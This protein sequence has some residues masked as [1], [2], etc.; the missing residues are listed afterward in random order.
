MRKNTETKTKRL[1]LLLG[2]VLLFG[3]TVNGSFTNAQ[4]T[5]PPTNNVNNLNA[6][7][8][9]ARLSLRKLT[10]KSKGSPSK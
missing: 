3:I 8:M 2:A 6:E 4:T 7:K 1:M 9:P 5:A 10:D